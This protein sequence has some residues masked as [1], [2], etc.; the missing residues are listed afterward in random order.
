MSGCTPLFNLHQKHKSLQSIEKAQHFMKKGDYEKAIQENKQA[1]KLLNNKYPGDQALYN[2]GLVWIQKDNPQFNYQ[3]SL[4]CFRRLAQEF[5]QS[6][7]KTETKTWIF[8][9]SDLISKLEKLNKLDKSLKLNQKKREE[10]KQNIKELKSKIDKLKTQLK[11]ND[12]IIKELQLQI[13]KLKE[14]DLELNQKKTIKFKKENF[15]DTGEN[16]GSG[17]R[18]EY[19]GNFKD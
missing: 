16:P 3:K 13:K 9:L 17:Q 12:K 2:M 8:I 6:N 4:Q 11:Q 19:T 1:L 18:S 5:T 10:Q 15:N 7:L 14:I